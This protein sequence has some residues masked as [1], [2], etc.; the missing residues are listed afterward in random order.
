MR[1]TAVCLSMKAR[2]RQVK[3]SAEVKRVYRDASRSYFG[4][5]YAQIAPE[6][7]RFLFESLY[8]R[9][10]TDA[11]A[12]GIEGLGVRMPLKLD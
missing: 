5:E 8:G 10:F 2:G 1:S 9:S 12:T 7:F 11:D 6:D 4:V 3:A